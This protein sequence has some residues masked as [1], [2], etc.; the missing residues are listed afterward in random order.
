MP[1]H[2]KLS[3]ARAAPIQYVVD[4]DTL[5]VDG[6]EFA[7]GPLLEGATLPREAVGANGWLLSDVTRVSGVIHMTILLPHGPNA[8]DLTRFPEPMTVSTD[9]PVTLPAYSLDDDEEDF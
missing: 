8:P 3:P 1:F 5:F 7:F 6:I 4:Q 9:G 2:F